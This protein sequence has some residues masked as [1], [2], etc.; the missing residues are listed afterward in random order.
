MQLFLS[1]YS[2]NGSKFIS[3]CD[4]HFSVLHVRASIN[5]SFF[6]SLF[7]EPLSDS[8]LSIFSLPARLG[9]MGIQDPVS[10]ALLAFQTS[11]SGTDHI[12][13]ALRGIEEFSMADQMVLNNSRTASRMEQDRLDNVLLESILSLSF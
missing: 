1:H 9:G 11:R 6:P 7:G 2:L 8:E 5:D 10:M 4:E 13:H 3:Q 12:I